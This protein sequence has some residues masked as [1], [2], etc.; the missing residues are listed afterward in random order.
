MSQTVRRVG[1]RVIG[2]AWD[3][4]PFKR[5]FLE[6][7]RRLGF[8]PQSVYQHLH[9]T[10]VF[11][12]EVGGTKINLRA[13]G[14]VI[15]N[16]IFWS[17]LFDG[18]EAESLKLWATL[19]EQSE[20]ILDIGANSGV[21][22][23]VAQAVNTSAT[24]VAFEPVE[25]VYLQLLENAGLNGSK[26]RCVEAAVS[27]VSGSVTLFEPDVEH[28]YAATLDPTV[29]GI[30]AGKD[31]VPVQVDGIRLDDF[32][33]DAQLSPDLIKIDT[34][35]HEPEVLRGLGSILAT[36][37]PALLLEVLTDRHAREIEGLVRG[38]G[39][40][41]YEVDEE[42]GAMPLTKGTHPS[43]GRN[44]LLCSAKVAEGLGLT[45]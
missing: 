1:R 39:Y 11:S 6:P 17:G 24:V 32:L 36:N 34:E 21:Y 25:R 2:A 29:F 3:L 33:Q 41:S 22:A 45:T 28:P 40:L 13:H 14:N 38:L 26:V 15:E 9:F 12:T 10:G 4:L 16:D 18:W 23:M 37:R 44:V 8:L 42:A 43:R 31:W 19:A 20:V 7:L 30:H 5:P 35:G 27:D